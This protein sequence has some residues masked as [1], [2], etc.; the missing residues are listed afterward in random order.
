MTEQIHQGGVGP[1]FVPGLEQVSIQVVI[2]VLGV[3]LFHLTNQKLQ[4]GIVNFTNLLTTVCIKE[5]GHRFSLRHP[6][7]QYATET[8][9]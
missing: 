9:T 8:S 5:S 3:F 6:L 4:L 1:L 7:V 2:L